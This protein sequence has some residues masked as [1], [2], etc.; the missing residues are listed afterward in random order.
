VT[1]SLA[2]GDSNTIENGNANMCLGGLNTIKNGIRNVCLGSRNLIDV[3][4]ESGKNGGYGNQCN[5]Q[6][7]QILSIN[8]NPV[9]L[10]SEVRGIGNTIED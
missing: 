1:N 3:K 5:G 4:Y 2:A 6:A 10:G 7:N 8:N 9:N